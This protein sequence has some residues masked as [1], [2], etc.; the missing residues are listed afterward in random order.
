MIFLKFYRKVKSTK[1]ASHDIVLDVLVPTKKLAP[2]GRRTENL[3]LFYTS[4]LVF[5]HYTLG[6]HEN[7]VGM[8]TENPRGLD[9]VP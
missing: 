1:F 7:L 4:A 8:Q 6:G 3:W 5:M 9:H 2:I